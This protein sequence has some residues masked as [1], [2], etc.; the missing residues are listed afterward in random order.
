MNEQTQPAVA[1][2]VEPTV[3]PQWK[4][5]SELPPR[6]RHGPESEVVLAIAETDDG[7]MQM[8]PARVVAMSKGEWREVR[9]DHTGTG[10]KLVVRCWTEMPRWPK[11]VP[12]AA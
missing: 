6:W 1:G 9:F 11:P 12:P 3:R 5:A 10:R 2:P 7:C 8:T 4:P